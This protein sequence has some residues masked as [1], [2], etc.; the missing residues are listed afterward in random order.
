[1]KVPRFA[2]LPSVAVLVGGLT[3]PLLDGLDII[4]VPSAS[5]ASLQ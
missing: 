5:L 3:E 2:Q 1:M 4:V